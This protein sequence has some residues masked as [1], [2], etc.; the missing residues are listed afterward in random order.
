MKYIK[1][2]AMVLFAG[3]LM[4]SCGEKVDVGQTTVE[5]AAAEYQSGFGGAYLYVPIAINGENA[6]AMNTTDVNVKIKVDETY[7]NGSV[8][9]GKEDEDFMITSYDMVFINNYEIAD[10]DKANPVQKQVGIEIKVLNTQ[11]EVMEFKLVIESANTTIGANKECV[12]RLEKTETDR[13]C[14]TY[15]MSSEYA[16]LFTSGPATFTTT[17]TVYWNSNYGCFEVLPFGT[18]DYTPFYIYWDEETKALYMQP[19]E[20]LMWYSSADSQMCYQMFVTVQ[21]NSVVPHNALVMLDYDIDAGIIRFPENLYFGITVCVCD[22]ATYSPQSWL[23]W[24]EGMHPGF[25]MTKQK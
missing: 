8:F 17:T 18:W 5:F 25:V 4:T 12:V 19:W 7:T 22:P 6:D 10:E 14:G 16:C 11:P 23:G 20:P 3:A 9:I 21:D 13:L 15:T 2:L 1:Y 24:M